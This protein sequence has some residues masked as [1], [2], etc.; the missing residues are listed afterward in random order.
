MMFCHLS[1]RT[2]SGWL[3]LVLPIMPRHI[4]S[5]FAPIEVGSLLLSEWA[6]R[7]L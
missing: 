2:W 5:H 6:T 3:I 1:A 7:A 4:G